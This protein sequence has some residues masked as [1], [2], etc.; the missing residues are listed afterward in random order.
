[1]GTTNTIAVPFVLTTFAYALA[2]KLI[3]FASPVNP[4]PVIVTF[5][6]TGPARGWSDVIVGAEEG[7]TLLFALHATRPI[8]TPHADS[9]LLTSTF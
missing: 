5:A 7:E 3:V 8:A 1:M 9:T 6:P 4:V 2:P